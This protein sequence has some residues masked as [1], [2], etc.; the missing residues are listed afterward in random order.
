MQSFW[1]NETMIYDGSQ[2]RSLFAYMEYEIMGDS[3]VSWRGGCD[4]SRDHMVDGEDLLANA[5]IR[6]SD[7]IH[8]IVECFDS[9]LGAAVGYQR[10]F[11]NIVREAIYEL[12][13][14]WEGQLQRDGDDLYF[15][16]RKLSISIATVSPVSALIHFAVNVNY[17]G[18]PV[19]TLGLRDLEVDPTDFANRVMEK[20]T[21]E[22]RSIKQAT[23]K[24][25]WVR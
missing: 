20:W 1:I 12:N 6:G 9:T 7:M 4:I 21:E 10:L 11:T 25:K 13:P 15:D 3:I 8:F 17:E 22:F 14:K 24:V 19:P 23:Q 5:E 2:L 16:K 18:T